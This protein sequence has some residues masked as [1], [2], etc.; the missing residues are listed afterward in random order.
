MSG[1]GEA[2]LAPKQY[3]AELTAAEKE[4][5]KKVIVEYSPTTMIAKGE[6]RGYN[7]GY[8]FLQKIYYELGLDYICKKIAKKLK[9]VKY[10]RNSIL[11]MLM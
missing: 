7:G 1:V 4:A 11:S 2:L 10:D 8:L 5:N 6:Q 3:I 9:M